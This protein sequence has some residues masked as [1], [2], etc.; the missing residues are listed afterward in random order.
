MA[1]APQR[2]QRTWVLLAVVTVGVLIVGVAVTRF[3]HIGD[4][5][6]GMI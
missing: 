6:S 4:P 3:V 1:V 2:P 5:V